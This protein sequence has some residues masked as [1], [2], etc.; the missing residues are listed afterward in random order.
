M[1][2]LVKQDKKRRN[3]IRLIEKKYFVLKYVF[4]N[5]NYSILIRWF[6]FLK[7]NL[8]TKNCS[9]FLLLNRC[10]CSIN[11]KRFNKLTVF[12]RHIFLKLI[13][14]GLMTGIYKST[15]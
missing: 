15:W 4:K 3:N 12:S 14:Q 10:L 9:K 8:L 1:K 2:K 5:L 6:V 7:L 11:K 13:Q